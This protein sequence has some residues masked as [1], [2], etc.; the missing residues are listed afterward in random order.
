MALP[1]CRPSA[2]ATSGTAFVKSLWCRL[3]LPPVEASCVPIDSS[4]SQAVCNSLAPVRVSASGGSGP[5]A[6]NACSVPHFWSMVTVTSALPLG[7]VRCLSL[8][9]RLHR[10]LGWSRFC[11]ELCLHQSR[12]GLYHHSGIFLRQGLHGSL[13]WLRFCGELCFHHSVSLLASGSCSL[14]SLPGLRSSCHGCC[15]SWPTLR[16]F[17]WVLASSVDRARLRPLSLAGAANV[18]SKTSFGVCSL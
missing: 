18:G 9:G 14:R 11:C 15:R 13:S 7:P 2:R 3:T 17:L 10:S 4:L 16:S 1:G 8:N 5:S 6:K 12:L